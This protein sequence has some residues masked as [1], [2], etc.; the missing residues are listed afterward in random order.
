MLQ[1][2]HISTLTRTTL[3]ICLETSSIPKLRFDIATEMSSFAGSKPAFDTVF[4]AVP[5]CACEGYGSPAR[6]ALAYSF[7][8]KS[9]LENME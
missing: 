9:E 7:G 1:F 6:V 2:I 3:L 4:A 8:S 5:T